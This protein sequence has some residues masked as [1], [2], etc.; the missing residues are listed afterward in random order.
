MFLLTL[1][2][3]FQVSTLSV[4]HIFESRSRHSL[5]SSALDASTISITSGRFY[6]S[7][8]E[9]TKSKSYFY[10]L[11]SDSRKIEDISGA[12]CHVELFGMIPKQLSSEFSNASIASMTN[13]FG[14]HW[15]CIYHIDDLIRRQYIQNTLKAVYY[16]CVPYSMDYNQVFQSCEKVHSSQALEFI[17]TLTKSSPGAK[18]PKTVSTQFTLT[19]PSKY[20]AAARR[21]DKEKENQLGGV[22]ATAP[23]MARNE[24]MAILIGNWIY[25]HLRL[26]FR[27]FFYDRNGLYKDIVMN[28]VPKF[29]WG[30]CTSLM[31]S[32]NDQ[33]YFLRYAP[34]VERFSNHTGCMAYYQSNLMSRLEYFD[35]TLRGLL[36]IDDRGQ[37]KAKTGQDKHLTYSHCRFEHQRRGG[38]DEDYGG[39]ESLL[40]IDFDEFVFCSS[41]GLNIIQ[42]RNA[43]L[44]LLDETN[45]DQTMIFRRAVGNRTSVLSYVNKTEESLSDCHRRTFNSN[46]SVFSCYQSWVESM[47]HLTIKSWHHSS[48]CLPTDYHAACH[49][50]CKCKSKISNKCGLF[51]LRP[52]RYHEIKAENK[53]YKMFQS[54]VAGNFRQV[55]ATIHNN[56]AGLGIIRL[57]SSVNGEIIENELARIWD[58]DSSTT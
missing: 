44:K 33:K 58:T 30:H 48:L 47:K 20:M 11:F 53:T 52:Q 51:H 41:A 29:V 26:G 9:F 12:P 57:R 2:L 10:K 15:K 4:V 27:V 3:S 25:H 31:K 7:N 46:S 8:I 39:V 16:F 28:V 21:L 22:V 24:N 40:V 50:G 18:F 42:Q 17:M 32:F 23:Y 36:N 54:T 35:Y 34:G 56:D 6:F 13:N 38:S 14:T 37:E 55:E 19:P 49:S 1:F 45:N 5:H 43:I